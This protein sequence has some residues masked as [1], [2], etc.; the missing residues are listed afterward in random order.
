MANLLFDYNHTEIVHVWQTYCLNIIIQ[1]WYTCGKHTCK[2]FT[3][4]SSAML[5]RP[6]IVLA[7]FMLTLRT[8]ARSFRPSLASWAVWPLLWATLLV[9]VSRSSRFL[10]KVS[11]YR[12]DEKTGLPCVV[13]PPSSNIHV[14]CPL[15]AIFTYIAHFQQYSRILPTSSNIHV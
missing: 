15:L 2:S 11:S 14:Y 4:K 13:S 8:S 10:S 3:P 6:E 1:K 9:H 7:C 12:T 5:W